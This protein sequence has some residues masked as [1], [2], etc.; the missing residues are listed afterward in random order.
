[1]CDDQI[2]NKPLVACFTVDNLIEQVMSKITETSCPQQ[3]QL[4]A[5]WEQQRQSH[6]E[7]ADKKRLENVEVGDRVD[8][9]DTE[10]IWL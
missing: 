7:W 9:R 5:K 2:R 10:Y 6:R 4:K 3:K 8:V 1:M